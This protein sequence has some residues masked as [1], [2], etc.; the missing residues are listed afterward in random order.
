MV[1]AVAGPMYAEPVLGGAHRY[2]SRLDVALLPVRFATADERDRF[3]A[4][5]MDESR[6]HFDQ[7]IRARKSMC[8]ADEFGCQHTIAEMGRARDEE[9]ARLEELRK[10]TP[11]PQ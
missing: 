8:R 10:A 2:P 9:L 5:R 6:L 11:A 4:N 7:P 1:A 3:F